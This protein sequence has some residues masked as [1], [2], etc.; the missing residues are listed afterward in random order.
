MLECPPETPNNF[1]PSSLEV[2][3]CLS[4][5]A[6]QPSAKHRM[7]RLFHPRLSFPL[8]ATKQQT[9]RT[10]KGGPYF[11]SF[12]LPRK[13]ESW[14]TDCLPACAKSLQSCQTP[15]TAAPPGPSV[16]GILQARILEWVAMP[17]SKGSSQPRACYQSRNPTYISCV[18]SIAGGFVA[19]WATWEAQLLERRDLNFLISDQLSHQWEDR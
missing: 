10:L 12:H 18:S 13:Q 19:F 1:F 14:L 11:V 7:K 8:N 17:S 6:T 9:N 16:H 15:G 3:Q 5:S 2:T 4:G